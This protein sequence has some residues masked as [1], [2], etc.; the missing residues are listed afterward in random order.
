MKKLISLVR[1]L[2]LVLVTLALCVSAAVSVASEK[3]NVLL[4]LAD[5][6]GYGD[7]GC[8]GCP[9]TKT[10]H[11]DKLA[12]DGVRCTFTQALFWLVFGSP[13]ACLR[14]SQP[15]GVPCNKLEEACWETLDCCHSPWH[16]DHGCFSCHDH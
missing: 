8:Y 7:V 1:K 12:R 10:P 14:G 9:D 5:D 13:T 3:P 6:L 2:A 16:M 15:T 4:I 11:M